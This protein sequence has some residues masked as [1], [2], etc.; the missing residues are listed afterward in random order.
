MRS[1]KLAGGKAYT[2]LMFML[3]LDIAELPELLLILF[4]LLSVSVYYVDCI[5]K[6]VLN[7]S[8]LLG[9][10]LLHLL[11]V[12]YHALCRSVL[13]LAH[14][15]VQNLGLELLLKVLVNCS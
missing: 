3:S 4:L 6:V 5:I 10:H 1:E 13:N 15:F 2:K 9:N 11:V 14:N 7:L 12:F 8:H